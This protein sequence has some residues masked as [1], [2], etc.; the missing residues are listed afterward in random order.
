[1]ENQLPLC[2]DV[3]TL[4]DQK[5]QY[6]VDQ[7]QIS[8]YHFDKPESSIAPGHKLGKTDEAVCKETANK[9]S[10]TPLDGFTMDY[11]EVELIL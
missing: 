7:K 6:H 10:V 8:T 3:P 9:P 11:Q 2:N 5:I 1:M 4:S